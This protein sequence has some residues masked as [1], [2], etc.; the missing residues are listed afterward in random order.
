MFDFVLKYFLI[1]VR[2]LA[3]VLAQ[4]TKEQSKGK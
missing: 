2:R 3:L 4:P 1:D